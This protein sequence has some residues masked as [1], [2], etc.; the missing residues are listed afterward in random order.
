M[1]KT[2]INN[3]NSILLKIN[4]ILEEQKT[5][6]FEENELNFNNLK[7]RELLAKAN[8]YEKINNQIMLSSQLN[9][10]FDLMNQNL[11]LLKEYIESVISIDL[12]VEKRKGSEKITEIQV[13][14]APVAPILPPSE[15]IYEI[16]EKIPLKDEIL[17]VKPVDDII[18][19]EN[20]ETE[21]IETETVEG[22]ITIYKDD[23]NIYDKDGNIIGKT[24]FKTYTIYEVLRDENGKIIAIRISPTG[25][26][27]Q[28]LYISDI[29]NNGL[30][31]F[32]DG[33]V[34]KFEGNKKGT[35]TVKIFN[36]K[37]IGIGGI[38]GILS[39]AAVGL[40]IYI[41]NKKGEKVSQLETGVYNVYDFT[42]DE[43]GNAKARISPMDDNEYW[44]N[45][46]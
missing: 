18:E 42:K 21:N 2:E 23:I 24:F 6:K 19:T 32:N 26:E 4:D 7:P 39:V 33:T 45:F 16:K 15:P 5:I 41:K 22:E 43:N 3:V 17:T 8:N 44:V 30:F 40:G 35:A 14:I 10:N 13:P 37:F 1:A 31:T 34:F 25:E 9:T 12:N 29:G 38:I 46:N 27:E 11:L 36:K 28:W 20:I